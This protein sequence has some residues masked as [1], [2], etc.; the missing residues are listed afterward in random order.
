MVKKAEL[1]TPAGKQVPVIMSEITK[2]ADTLADLGPAVSLF[3]SA[4]ISRQSPYYETSAAIAAA[5][6]RAGFA[7]IAGGG[8]G[9]MEAANKGA[10]EAG[11]TSVGLNISLPHE[12]TNN[13]YQTISLSFE[14]FYS[15]KA[16]F[17]MH[18]MAYVALPGG[19]GTLDELFEALTLVQTGKVPPA[20]IVLV[21]RAYWGGLVDWL[22]EQLRGNGMIGVHDLNLFSIEDD[23]DRVV[24]RI[25]EFH[26][27]PDA[28][29]APSLP[30]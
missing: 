20:P 5:L 25:V 23:P 21:G 4:R 17:F 9:I 22:D 8:P 24:A 2:A 26:R 6:A 19:F 30:A 29:Y 15:R 28:E 11:G 12:T 1:D 13:A 10:Y 14:Y 3:G 7:V 18:S 16:T 27:Q